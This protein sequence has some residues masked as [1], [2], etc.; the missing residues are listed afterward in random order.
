MSKKKIRK[1]EL[2]APAKNAEIGME[3]IIH[4]ADA[5]YIGAP[6]FGARAAAGNSL[7]EITKLA[8]FAKQYRARVFVALNTI[9]EDKDLKEAEAMIWDLY[10]AGVDAVI[11]QDMG[12][13][14]LDLPPIEL[15]ASTQ[16]DNRTLDKV[17]ELENAGF[18]QIVLARE[19]PLSEI[20]H[21]C[22]EVKTP[23]EVFIH[24]ALCVSYSGQC[25]VSQA[26]HNRSANRGACAQ[27]CRLPFDLVDADGKAILRNKHLLS[28]KDMNRSDKLEEMLDAGV[29]SLKIEGRLKDMS[30]VK[31]IVA[32][33][34]KK[35]DEIFTRRPDEFT[36]ASSGKS[37]FDF[38]PNPHK[39]FSRGFTDYF[40]INGKTPH[41]NFETPKSLGEPVGTIKFIEK[42][43]IV[44]AGTAILNNG[45]GFCFINDREEFFGFRA[46]RV[47]GNRIYLSP[48]MKAIPF[49]KGA[50]LYRNYD[51]EF[52][53]TLA[54]KSAERKIPVAIS[55]KENPFG[56][57]LEATDSDGV[58]ATLVIQEEKQTAQK[59]QIKNITDQ[60][61]KLGT[62]IFTADS[63]EI[64]FTEEF[65]FP[66]SK[67][68][69]WRRQLIDKL[70]EARRITHPQSLRDLRKK[71]A[72]DSS[73]QKE[74]LSYLANV[75][76]QA[77]KAFYQQRGFTRIQPAFEI[78]SQENVPLMFMKHCIRYSLGCCSKIKGNKEKLKEPLFLVNKSTRLR[79]EFDCK[80]CEM[81]IYK[82]NEQK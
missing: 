25:F 14:S 77:A 76:N 34:R 50:R 57:T 17:K 56:F 26:L 12:I 53:K 52:E 59:P 32:F 69:D 78:E 71:T 58:S 40:D 75:S 54:K 6:K 21:I 51:H 30:Y 18:S 16:T 27:I 2:L 67:L 7:E 55:L 64:D 48:D 9:L 74:E 4:G 44:V 20:A 37:V 80:Q 68:A 73:P 11:I 81:R 60:L 47:E 29:T 38:T 31:N 39:S 35:L 61:S 72:A 43:S 79:L 62:T 41:Y 13:L 63:V 19:L 3:A 24:G 5:V 82:D 28:M 49:A 23:I 65:F 10:K 45:D 70:I 1:I 8:Q 66:A 42:G 33:Y 15:H 36:A 22:S 46:N